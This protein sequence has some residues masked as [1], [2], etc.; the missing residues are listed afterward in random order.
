MIFMMFITKE[1]NILD[2]VQLLNF[3][4]TS[5]VAIFLLKELLK[6]IKISNKFDYINFVGFIV[7]CIFYPAPY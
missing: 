1:A 5:K 2:N 3:I 7:C 4:Q 6:N